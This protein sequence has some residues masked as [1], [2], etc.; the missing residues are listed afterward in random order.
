M[1][2][3]E[4]DVADRQEFSFSSVVD[5][6][7][8]AA[9]HGKEKCCTCYICARRFEGR[10]LEFAIVGGARFCPEMDEVLDC[11]CRLAFFGRIQVFPCFLEGGQERVKGDAVL[12][13]TGAWPVV[14]PEPLCQVA[15]GLFES[16]CLKV[17]HRASAPDAI[18][19]ALEEGADDSS[20][21]VSRLEL[22]QEWVVVEA[23][24][25][26]VPD[27]ASPGAVLFFMGGF[28]FSVED[29]GNLGATSEIQE[30]ILLGRGQMQKF[31]GICDG[32]ISNSKAVS[33]SSERSQRRDK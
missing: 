31:A 6:E 18:T 23:E 13:V 12:D 17:L 25:F 3:A 32:K 1:A 28:D 24:I 16:A 7:I 29:T 9:A 4:D 22:V 26:E 33:S 27:P 14:M 15:N 2:T 19:E 8:F 10:K 20:S 11:C 21:E 5:G 30:S